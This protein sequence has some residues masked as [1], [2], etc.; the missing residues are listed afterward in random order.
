MLYPEI[1]KSLERV[2][3]SLEDDIP[4]GAFADVQLSDEQTQSIK[5]NA[6]T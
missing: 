3:S 1:Y 5:M 6:C 4:W 2:H